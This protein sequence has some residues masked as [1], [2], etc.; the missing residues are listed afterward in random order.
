MPFG[1]LHCGAE[2]GRFCGGD[3]RVD[4]V[5]EVGRQGAFPRGAQESEMRRGGR[6][7]SPLEGSGGARPHRQPGEFGAEA[8]RSSRSTHP[9]ASYAS[10]PKVSDSSPR[11]HATQHD[12]ASAWPA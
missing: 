8:L 4:E 6:M 12:T 7:V 10:S 3:G 11:F 2:G 5:R 9:Q 1:V